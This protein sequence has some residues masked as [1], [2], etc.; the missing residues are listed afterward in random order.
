MQ[1]SYNLGLS[2][3]RR[4]GAGGA[5]ALPLDGFPTAPV[6]AYSLNRRLLTSY[7]NSRLF[8]IREVS[9]STEQD[10]TLAED[11]V[12]SSG[13]AAFGGAGVTK[14]IST[15]YN[16][17][18]AGTAA[19][20]VGAAAAQHEIYSGPST[21]LRRRGGGGTGKLALDGVGVGGYAIGTWADTTLAANPT[22][23]AT[24]EFAFVG[25]YNY[26]GFRD[27]YLLH[28]TDGLMSIFST[29]TSNTAPYGSALGSFPS[30][31]LWAGENALSTASAN[32]GYRQ[33]VNGEQR[34]FGGTP[35]GTPQRTDFSQAA[36][37]ASQAYTLLGQGSAGWGSTEVDEWCEFA[38][39]NYKPSNT[40]LNS[41]IANAQAYYTS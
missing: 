13:I 19:D 2:S 8:R 26:R 31:N 23:I 34:V 24:A 6:F 5:P 9:G 22:T 32:A 27:M 29:T 16:Q 3:L 10:V 38:W 40:L 30:A 15:I 37:A 7:S 12:N 39:F 20:A 41:Y 33:G 36:L 25:V 11:E 14:M 4:R 21:L 18:S 35:I 1:L 17:G 28:G